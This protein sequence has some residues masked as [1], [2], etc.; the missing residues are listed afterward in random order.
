MSELVRVKK[1]LGLPES[2]VIFTILICSHNLVMILL[3]TLDTDRNRNCDDYSNLCIEPAS[4]A[5]P[6][7]AKIELN[8][9][10]VLETSPQI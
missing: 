1:I 5:N 10:S 6:N 8:L 4:L 3:H 7:A 2:F 9:H